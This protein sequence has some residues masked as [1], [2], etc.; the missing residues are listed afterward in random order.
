MEKKYR[1]IFHID[2]NA[3]FASCEM[4]QDE[5]L[6]DK[7]LGIG[8]TTS[9]G[10]LST[11]NYVARKFGIHSGMNVADAKR[12]CP[13]IILL[14][15]NFDLYNDYS[16]KFFALLGEYVSDIEK[17]SIDEGYL[18]V[19]KLSETIHPLD[20]AKEIQE[21]LVQE[22]NLPVSIGIAPNMFL[23]KMASDMKKPLGVTVLRKRD[24]EH[25][26]WP[27]PIEDMYG[28][29]KK[30]YPNLKLIG[31]HT[32]GDLVH[33]KD[34]RKLELILGNRVDEFIA[35]AKGFD[36]RKVEPNRYVDMK[37]VGNSSTYKTDLYEYQDVLDK[38]M[39]LTKKVASRLEEDYSVCKTISI[40]VRYNDFTQINRSYTTDRYTDNVFEIYEVVE[41]LYDD[42]QS[43]KPIRL[44]GVSVSNLIDKEDN[45]RQMNIFEV[46]KIEEKEE[47]VITLLSKINQVYGQKIIKKGAK[48]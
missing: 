43:D 18:D 27:L 14:P 15:G 9:R 3:F 20:L 8:G 6:R 23:A 25:K 28:I 42:N 4:A 32:I 19:T 45:V 21:R 37:S 13:Q 12:L 16:Q 2:L 36:D 33:C 35:K 17:G 34:R 40:Q 1:I 38:L 47:A 22:H 46:S 11:A 7:P 26:L 29:G 30:T 10:V 48:K 39:K 5:S 24:I 31:V 41:R 44:L